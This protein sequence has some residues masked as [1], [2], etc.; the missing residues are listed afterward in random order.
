MSYTVCLLRYN[1]KQWLI[2]E[3]AAVVHIFLSTTLRGKYLALKA[4]KC[5]LLF[6]GER[7]TAAAV[8]KIN[9]KSKVE[10]F[11][12][13]KYHSRSVCKYISYCFGEVIAGFNFLIWSWWRL[14]L[15]SR[16]C[17]W[18][19]RAW[20][21][22]HLLSP[23]C[24][25]QGSR[26]CQAQS[27]PHGSKTLELHRDTEVRNCEWDALHYIHLFLQRVK[28]REHAYRR[29]PLQ[30]N[31]VHSFSNMKLISLNS[32]AEMLYTPEPPD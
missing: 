29:W 5:Y 4:A 11:C 7:R 21:E 16:R 8:N 15:W 9:K 23:L 10:D 28:S 2:K 12:M 22:P 18:E 32:E 6:H 19:E 24:C 3:F 26:C 1:Q 14:P 27:I 17:C 31:E 20:S 25:P 13:A 30:K